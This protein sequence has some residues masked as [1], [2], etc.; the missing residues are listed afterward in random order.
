MPVYKFMSCHCCGWLSDIDVAANF[1][2]VCFYWVLKGDGGLQLRPS[3]AT[4]GCSITSIVIGHRNA[5]GS[6]ASVI[7]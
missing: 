3:D 1:L 5:W 6:A 2:S 7:L 4:A